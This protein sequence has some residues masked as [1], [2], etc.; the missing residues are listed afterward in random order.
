M[1][2]LIDYLLTVFVVIESMIFNVEID[3]IIKFICIYFC[4]TYIVNI[5]NRLL[6]TF[7]Y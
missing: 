3:I 7:Y 2:L 6:N 5:I 1:S 4:Y